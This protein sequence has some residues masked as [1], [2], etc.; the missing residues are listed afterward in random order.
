MLSIQLCLAVAWGYAAFIARLA[1]DM[2]PARA[3]AWLL[4][5]LFLTMLWATV[6]VWTLHILWLAAVLFA[7]VVALHIAERRMRHAAK[8]AGG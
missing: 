3:K 5:D 2:L 6:A 7:V 1:P 4:H 8:A